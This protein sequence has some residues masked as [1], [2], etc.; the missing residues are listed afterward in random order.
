MSIEIL[1]GDTEGP[2]SV[3][4]SV[5]LSIR[6]TWERTRMDGYGR[7]V[8]KVWWT[9]PTAEG[10]KWRKRHRRYRI[11]SLSRFVL[12]NDNKLFMTRSKINT[13][14]REHVEWRRWRRLL[15]YVN[16]PHNRPFVGSWRN[17]VDRF[18]AVLLS[19]AND[20]YSD[21]VSCPAVVLSC[22]IGEWSD[23]TPSG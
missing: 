11:S 10:S 21:K 12:H 20:Y 2:C 17:P 16:G 18:R 15:D 7:L 1:S 19:Q 9:E 22:G 4:T 3:V 13:R 23:Y 5:N 14:R 8:S 6:V